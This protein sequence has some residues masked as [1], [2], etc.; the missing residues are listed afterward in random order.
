MLAAKS[1]TATFNTA[2][3]TSYALTVSKAGSGTGPVTS[4]PSGIACGSTC[5]MSLPAGTTA[6]LTATANTG[7]LFAG[8]S[9]DCTGGVNTCV[10]SMTANR[11]VTA[12]FVPTLPLAQALDNTGLQWSSHGNAIWFAQT[13]ITFDGVDAAQSGGLAANQFSALSTSVLGPGTLSFRWRV[14]SQPGFDL[15]SFRLDGAVLTSIS[16]DSG[17]QLQSWSIPAGLHTLEWRYAKD[18][19]ISSNGDRAWVDQVQYAF[20]GSAAR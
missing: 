5:S 12:A 6:T 17:W 9:G 11:N 1:V 7:S 4:S 15:L 8:W 20:T 16:G 2:T 10:V 3:V 14:A 13:A 18:G 19:S